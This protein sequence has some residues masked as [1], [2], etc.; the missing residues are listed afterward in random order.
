[1]GSNLVKDSIEVGGTRVEYERTSI[2]LDL[3]EKIISWGRYGLNSMVSLCRKDPECGERYKL[4]EQ[5]MGILG[6]ALVSYAFI[7][8]GYPV[9]PDPVIVGKSERCVKRG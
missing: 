4:I 9:V 6:N 1:M 5:G 7:R 2:S 8:R 3:Y